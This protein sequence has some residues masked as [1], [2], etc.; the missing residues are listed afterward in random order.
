[1]KMIV[2]KAVTATAFCIMA[3]DVSASPI[4]FN[5]A[6]PLSEDELLLRSLLII[7]KQSSDGAQVDES[8]T[9]YTVQ[10]VAG[11]GITPRLAVFG[12]LPTRYID[13]ELSSNQQND[14]GIGDAELFA[15]FE[16]LRLD[17]QGR[18]FRISPFAGIR[19]PSGEE[20][21][22]G[23]GSTD[24]FGGLILT[25]ASIKGNFDAQIRWNVNGEHG[26]FDR[27]NSISFDASYQKRLLPSE[28]T[29]STKGF[30][31]GVLEANV[32]YS[33]QNQFGGIDDVNSGGTQ[34]SITPGLQ[35]TAR[36]WVADLGIKIPLINDTNGALLEADYSL[37]AGMRFNF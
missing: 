27:G 31:F 15:R 5:T 3:G 21:E 7:N 37:F 29:T 25:S 16:L 17:G 10:S 18:T 1:M 2:L 32:T 36:R 34:V 8:V 20:G 12:I 11:Y 28:I 22:T 26:G 24:Y 13:R 33:E 14:F 4:T 19:V 30:F 9:S 23:D 6:L 35:Y